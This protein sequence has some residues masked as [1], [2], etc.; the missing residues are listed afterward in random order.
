[1][2][3]EERV[4]NLFRDAF[5]RYGTVKRFAAKEQIFW[6]D[7]PA[8]KTYYLARG[9]V[10]AYL[11]YPDGVERTLCYV[12]RDSLVG[13]EALAQ[14]AKRI[15]CADAT[16]SWKCIPWTA[17]SCGNFAPTSRSCSRS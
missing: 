1:M 14:P 12:D 7:D 13:E 4:P 17:R 10:R 3:N 2:K 11:L 5:R 15:V 9:R 8:D 6:K 16:T